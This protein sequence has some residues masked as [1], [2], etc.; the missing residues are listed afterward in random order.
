MTTAVQFARCCKIS[1]RISASSVVDILKYSR[2][3]MKNCLWTHQLPQLSTLPSRIALHEGHPQ[4]RQQARRLSTTLGRPN[5]ESDGNR[6]AEA[7]QAATGNGPGSEERLN[8]LQPESSATELHQGATPGPP[9]P[10]PTH[11]CMSGC[12]N[13]VWVQHAEELL[14]Y[15]QDGEE[16]ALAAVEEHVQD[17]NLKAFLKMEIRL[18][19]TT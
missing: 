14:K 7:L 18:M 19:K 10:P 2:G 3:C 15:Y 6:S 9:P 1:H 17:E 16:K 5:V 4:G 12:N 8:A 13:C 11:C